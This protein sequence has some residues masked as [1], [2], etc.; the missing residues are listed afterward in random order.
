VLSVLLM[1][2]AASVIARVIDEHRW[3]A[4]VGIV[5]IVLAGVVMAWEDLNHFFPQNIPDLPRW[6]G[7]PY[8]SAALGG[9]FARV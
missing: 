3:I 2:I 7:G 6:L 8:H 9:A 5:V 4:V 1:G